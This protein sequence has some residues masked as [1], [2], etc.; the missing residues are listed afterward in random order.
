[1][2]GDNDLILI[3]RCAVHSFLIVAASSALSIVSV[4][5][6]RCG[7]VGGETS[8]AEC[9]DATRSYRLNSS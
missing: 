8:K 2:L 5:F 9:D 3:Y 4:V 7:L 1:M 6:I